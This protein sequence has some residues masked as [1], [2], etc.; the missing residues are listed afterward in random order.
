MT[1]E[2]INPLD[3]II[4]TN[5]VVATLIYISDDRKIKSSKTVLLPGG[6]QLVSAEINYKQNDEY[7]FYLK[8]ITQY[9]SFKN[10]YMSTEINDGS[11]V[12]FRI[13]IKFHNLIN[14]FEIVEKFK[15]SHLNPMN[16]KHVMLVSVI[17]LY[18]GFTGLDTSKWIL[19]IDNFTELTTLK[20]CY[21]ER[22]ITYNEAKNQIFKKISEQI[23]IRNN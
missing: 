16:R 20:Q 3:N 10:L 7:W 17:F 8:D 11:I 15:Y 21:S 5:A 14:R 22:L 1:T 19:F 18:E 6:T 23:K 9:D 2:T 4:L 13:N 12:G